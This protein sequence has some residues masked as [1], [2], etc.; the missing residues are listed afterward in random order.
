M[1][2]SRGPKSEPCGTPKLILHFKFIVVYQLL[3]EID[4]M[5]CTHESR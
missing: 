1:V 4:T 3:L 5:I 2:K